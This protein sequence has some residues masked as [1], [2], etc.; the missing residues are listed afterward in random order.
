M[1]W[2]FGSIFQDKEEEKIDNFIKK[3]FS[4]IDFPADNITNCYIDCDLLT[5][6]LLSATIQ[7]FVFDV[8]QSF[9]DLLVPTVDT[10]KINNLI[11]IHFD[12]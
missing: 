12:N 6:G 3:K 1:A 10:I 8:S 4:N 9:W 5:F 2:T 7:P 11:G